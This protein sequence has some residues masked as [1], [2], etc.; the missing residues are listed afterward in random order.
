MSNAA[1]IVAAR[2][3]FDSGK[4]AECIAAAGNAID[5]KEPS[6]NWSLLKIRSELALGRYADA[7][8]TLD[9]ALDRFQASVQL[10]WLGREVARFNGQ[11]ERA[12]ELTEEIGELVRQS[13]WRFRDPA[14]QITLGRF[15]LS[16]GVDAKQVLDRIFNQV[17]KQQPNYIE[18]YLASGELALEKHDD[19]LAAEVFEE[20][21][22][23]NPAVPE[24]QLGLARAY[25][26][27]DPEKSRAALEAALLRNPNHVESL[28]LVA[29]DHVDSERYD[30]AAET[31]RRIEAI[32]AEHPLLW[33]YR[34][35]LAHLDNKPEV[36]RE[37]RERALRTWPTNPQVDHTIG[38][39]LSQ[40]Y[41]FAEGAKYQR[42]AL[43]FDADYLPAEIQLAQDL[44]R[45]GDEDDGWP[46]A[47]AV[48]DQDG[49]NVV[50]HNLVELHDN[51]GKFRTLE[52]G[53]FLLR[54][55]PREAE[56]YGRRV[57]D[58]LQRAKQ[59]LCA[60][61]D[62]AIDEPVIVEMFPRQQDFA[63][64]T[65]G[66][67]GGAGFLGVCFGRVITAN[68]PASQG[69]HPSNWQATLWHEF[70]HVVTLHKTNNKMPR[71]LSEGISVYEERQADA[72][73]GQSINPRYHE[74]MLDA[75]LTPVSRLSGAF[76]HPQT[77]LDLQFAYFESSLVVEYLVE[78]HGLDVLKRILVDLGVGMP[79][80]D[81]L[82]RHTG[83]LEFLD[84]EFGEFAHARAKAMAPKADWAEPALPPTA[85]SKEL[86]GWVEQHPSNYPG[87]KRL[88]GLLVEEKQSET[89]EQTLQKMLELYP[90]DAGAGNPYAM[91]ATVY[92]ERND[93][94][95]ER[96]V[97]EKLAALS[98]DDVDVFTR[99]IELSMHAEDWASAVKYGMRLL[100]INP[101]M[102]TPYRQLATAAEKTGDDTLAIDCYRAQLLL[103]PIDPADTHFRLALALRRA[104]DLA[105]AKRQ[106]L[107]ALEEAPR[108]RAALNELLAIVRAM[109]KAEQPAESAVE[110]EEKP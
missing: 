97:L 25:A 64:R 80:N 90:Q 74:M 100:A 42:Q 53:G 81:A 11:P 107:E 30:Q 13:S 93:V 51:L 27:S 69:D 84:R 91:L 62:V 47:N 7:Q 79:I 94:E 14:N 60:K 89:A 23:L 49:Y 88:A 18:A 24:A 75:R 103:D 4:Y 86:A 56:I 43:A 59:T 67:P 82:A 98:A 101:L 10:R 58:L 38:A 40:K 70:C 9:A 26:A 106:A 55:D 52:G 1:D 32:N 45:L 99:L 37:C 28:L 83:S 85:T 3:L 31:L 2:K 110:Q 87:L 72:T 96:A 95:Q 104:G 46:L 63:I 8:K 109:Q 76:L 35:V 71:W 73:W 15:F 12:G 39:K 6:E 48:Y 66:L 20:A 33:A 102:R 16:Q 22:K 34:A 17:K 50:A 92:R 19:A 5:D 65:F 21:A 105:G 36:E 29:D 108:Y 44:L 61:Y 41:R 78:K 68:S 54:M 77:P 57:L